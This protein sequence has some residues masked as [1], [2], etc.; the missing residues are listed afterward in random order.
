[1]GGGAPSQ[2]KARPRSPIEDLVIAPPI[3][4][5]PMAPTEWPATILIRIVRSMG[6]RRPARATAGT[7]QPSDRETVTRT[8]V[9]R[10]TVF[11]VLALAQTGGVRLRHGDAASCR[12][13]GSSRS[14]WRSSASSR[15]C[16]PGSRS[17]SGRRSAAS[18]CCAGGAIVTPSPD[19]RRPATADRRP[20]RAPRS[21]C[22]SATRTWRA[23]SPG[24]ARPT[25][26]SPRTGAL[27]HFDFFVLSDSNEPDTLVAERHAWR[28]LLRAVGRVRPHLL[29]LAPAPHQ[30]QERQH[31]RLLPALGQPLPLHGRPRRRQRDERRV[32]HDAGAA[33]GGEPDRRHHPD[34]AAR[35]P[36]ATRSI[37]RM[38]QFATRVYGPLFTAGLHFWQLGESHYWGHNAIIRVAPF[39]RHCALGRLPGRGPLRRARSCPTTSSRRR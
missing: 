4:R 13:T 24:C 17:D 21:S 3:R 39:M 1:M 18:C 28:D 8:A 12:T 9:L 16:S 22:R 27:R 5:T 7:S 25:S 23:C 20:T 35:A 19:R 15:S 32:P 38:Q 31:R 10:R 11:I 29:P 14:S 26:R 36:G 6:A 30:A 37:A 34:R 33:D 2:P